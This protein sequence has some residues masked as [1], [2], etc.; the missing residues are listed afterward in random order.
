MC[1]CFKN[2]GYRK[3]K[4]H[5]HTSCAWVMGTEMTGYEGGSRTL[6]P[7]PT[8]GSICTK[9]E[10][11]LQHR[12]WNSIVQ[13]IS[14]LP[15]QPPP[16]PA[17]PSVLSSHTLASLSPKPLLI[18]CLHTTPTGSLSVPLK[19]TYTLANHLKAS[20]SRFVVLSPT[21]CSPMEELTLW[22]EQWAVTVK[23]P[24]SQLE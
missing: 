24:D 21:A 19:G 12:T 3:G 14:S 10:N 20:P 23:G 1:V 11:K 16:F 7:H 18:Q 5:A 8:L 9:H 2:Y 4:M 13:T 22:Q 15:E 17:G 6:T